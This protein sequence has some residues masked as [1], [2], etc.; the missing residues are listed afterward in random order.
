MAQTRAV[1]MEGDILEQAAEIYRICFNAPDKGEN[2]TQETA[3]DYYSGLRNKD[4]LFWVIEKDGV[5]AG[6]C[7]G[8]PLEQSDIAADMDGM[9]EGC[10]YYAVASMSPDFQGSGLGSQMFADWLHLMKDT[11]Y[12]TVIG[13]CRA[14]NHAML[15]IFL[16][17]GFQEIKRYHAE[18]GGVTCARVLLRKQL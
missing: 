11:H 2:W 5:M 8:C 7:G 16:K 13:R 18:M 6:V 17:N 1:K 9:E 10:F 12:Q 4:G 14:D 3:K 15:R